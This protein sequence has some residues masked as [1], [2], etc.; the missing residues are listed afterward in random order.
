MQE[1]VNQKTVALAFS[2]AKLTGRVLKAAMQKYL[3][4]SKSAKVAANAKAQAKQREPTH[5]KM[6]V[7]DLVGQGQGATTIEI[8]HSDI[9]DFEKVAAKYN[10][11]FAVKKDVT[12]QPPKYLV[13]FKAKDTD[14]ISQAFKEYVHQKTRQQERPSLKVKLTRLRKYVAKNKDRQREKVKDR[15]RGGPNL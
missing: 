3:E 1:E 13:F 11:D 9:K 15:S 4:H 12:E 2:A 8:K 6:T 7:E 5:G 14:V 10:V